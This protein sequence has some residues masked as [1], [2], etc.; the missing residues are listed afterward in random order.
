[1]YGEV[2]CATAISNE[3]EGCSPQNIL[4][5]EEKTLLETVKTIDLMDKNEIKTIDISAQLSFVEIKHQGK[6][7]II[8]RTS[9]NEAPMCP[10]FCIQPM[11]IKGVLTVGEL[12]TLNFI[13]KLKEK[14][15]RLLVDARVNKEYKTKT[16]PGA[17]NLPYKML[18]ERSLYQEEVL[19]LLGAKKK[20]NVKSGD[21]W[22]FKNAQLLLIFGGGSFSSEAPIAI[23][24]LLKMGYPKNKILYYRGGINSWKASG[25]TLI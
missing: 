6:E 9:S 25:L 1:M 4:G 20:L 24:Q 11:Q 5:N 19:K 7:L 8:E 10:P 18:N 3:L 17:I 22:F 21:K 16:I 13:E 2:G 15:S 23:K 14:K 12:E